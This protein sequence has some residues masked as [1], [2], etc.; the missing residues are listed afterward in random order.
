MNAEL[1]KK[2]RY[3][4]G[5]AAAV[6]NSPPGFSLGN[7]ASDS[8]DGICDFVLL[9]VNNARDTEEWLP[10]V[11]PILNEDALFWIAYPKQSSKI[12]TDINRDT[13]NAIVQNS[14]EY[15]AVSNVSVDETWSA[16]RFRPQSKV[17]TRK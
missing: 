12:K 6:L 7:E 16:L 13:L 5:Q 15:R 14:S 4:S 10:R 11:L 1:L 17:N 2:L 8:T 9:F 3:K